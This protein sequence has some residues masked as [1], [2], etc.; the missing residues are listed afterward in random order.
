LF[1]IASIE[2]ANENV[3]VI[4]SDDFKVLVHQDKNSSVAATNNAEIEY[5]GEEDE[6]RNVPLFRKQSEEALSFPS[7]VRRSRSSSTSSCSSESS[8]SSKSSDKA[9]V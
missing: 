5:A 8:R 2:Q 1:Q 4:P 7:E 3:H 9:T 6:S